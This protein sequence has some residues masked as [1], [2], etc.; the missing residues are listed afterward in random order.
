MLDAVVTGPPRGGFGAGV[1]AALAAESESGVAPAGSD[2]APDHWLWLLHDDAVPAADTLQQLLGHVVTDPSIDITGP[3]LVFP[4]R[5]HGAGHQISEVG[6]SIAR[7]GRRDL[8]LDLG[9]IDQGQRDQPK[10]H[11]GVSTCGMLV[12]LADWRALDGLDPDVACFRD[13]VELGWRATARGLRVVTTPRAEMVH[14][15]VGR[16]GLRPRGAGG[17]HP[18]RVDQQLGLLLVAGHAPTWRLPFAWLRLVLDCLIRALGYLLGKAP[19]RVRGRARHPRLAVRRIPAGSGP[20]GAGCGAAPTAT[21]QATEN[22][23]RTEKDG[24]R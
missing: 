16:A 12:R 7:T 23:R 13:G 20:T 8:G 18:D 19:R 3:K 24:P 22:D 11:L 17:R 10:Q 4:R 6:V 2:D 5:R 9:E 21:R 1:A 14:R 15:Q